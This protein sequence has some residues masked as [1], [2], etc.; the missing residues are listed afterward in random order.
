MAL[1]VDPRGEDFKGRSS[2]SSPSVA[3]EKEPGFWLIEAPP[4]GGVVG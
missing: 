4:K 2:Q 1:I 3:M